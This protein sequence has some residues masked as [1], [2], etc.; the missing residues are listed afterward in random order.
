MDGT[1]KKFDRKNGDG[2]ADNGQRELRV[3][4]W[5]HTEKHGNAQICY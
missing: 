1:E 3:E 4:N 2:T 5:G